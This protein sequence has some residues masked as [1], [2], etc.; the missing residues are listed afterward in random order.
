M[1]VHLAAELAARDLAFLHVSEPDWAGGE[2]Y[3][4]AFREQLRRAFP[5]P[6]VG[7]GA[8][9][10]AKAERLLEAG[11]ADERVRLGGP[12]NEPDKQTFYGGGAEGYVD[13][14]TLQET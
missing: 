6:I 1:A 11:L 4:D 8:Y 10:V 5:G 2:P 14:P 9:D 12:F 13:Y 3:T 7:A